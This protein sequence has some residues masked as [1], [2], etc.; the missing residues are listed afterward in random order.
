MAIP[1]FHD[2]TYTTIGEKDPLLLHRWAG[3]SYSIAV[4][5]SMGGQYTLE[6]TLSRLD[7]DPSPVWFELVGLIDLTTSV[8]DVIRDTPLEAIRID[9]QAIDMTMRL[10]VRQGGD[11]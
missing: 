2:V 4:V 3:D 1:A 11:G 8:T 10:Q 7:I 5:T 6:G 9:I